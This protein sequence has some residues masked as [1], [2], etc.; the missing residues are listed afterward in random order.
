MDP[1]EVFD[2]ALH[3]NLKL[4]ADSS[5]V[6]ILALA[7]N[8]S[9]AHVTLFSTDT[10]QFE[11]FWTKLWLSILHKECAVISG[12]LLLYWCYVLKLNSIKKALGRLSFFC[13]CFSEKKLLFFFSIDQK[14]CYIWHLLTFDIYVIISANGQ[15]LTF[16]TAIL[17]YFNILIIT[18]FFIIYIKKTVLI[19]N[20]PQYYLRLVF[21]EYDG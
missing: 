4:T 19:L 10:I 3:A 15:S 6:M 5:F 8:Y 14:A 11:C 12:F 7:S 18:I 9:S 1:V 13:F 20:M 16:L 2:Q 17:F 21:L